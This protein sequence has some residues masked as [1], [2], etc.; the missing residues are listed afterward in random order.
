MIPTVALLALLP[1]LPSFYVFL[2]CTAL[3]YSIFA[4]SLDFLMGFG[5][6]PNF[7]QAVFFGIGA[8]VV[9]MA[10]TWWQLPLIVG[11]ALPYVFIV[12]LSYVLGR[13]SIRGGGI[14]FAML[15]LIWGDIVYRIF[16][17]EW[18][19]GGSDGLRGAVTLPTQVYYVLLV[20]A[21]L[22]C[23]LLLKR[24]IVSSQF[25]TILRAI[26]ENE[27]RMRYV[28][29]NVEKYKVLAFVISAC[30]ATFAGSLYP[31]LYGGARPE[32]LHW[33]LSTLVV[34]MVIV[35]GLGTL[36]G[37]V[38]GGLIVTFVIEWATS[39]LPM[40][41]GFLIAGLFLVIT[42]LFMPQGIYPAIQ[43]VWK[44]S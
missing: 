21:T 30:F 8:Y 24:R 12:P 7:G 11:I 36:V 29:C 18:T 40:G 28:G 43:R 6:M 4:L 19:L 16:F 25:G 20:L 23:Y 31:A 33:G 10:Q 35:G 17:Y 3:I 41:G 15:T 13:V 14:Y 22:A 27:T 44:K 32:L 39:Y 2:L 42:L 1:V 5:G 26:R 9:T 37:A 38:V 34:A